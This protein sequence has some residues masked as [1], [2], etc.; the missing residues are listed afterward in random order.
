MQQ[1]EVAVAPTVRVVMQSSTQALDE[2]IVVA[3][4]TSTKASFTGSASVLKTDDLV[5]QRES[6]VK[7]LQG[8][9][10]GVQVG[11]TTGDPGANQ[12]IQIRGISSYSAS[13]QPLYVIDGVAVVNDEHKNDGTVDMTFSQKSQSVLASLNPEDIESVTVLKDA[14]AASLYGSRAANGVIIITTK[15]GKQGS[16]KVSYGAEFGWS[17]MAVGSQYNTMNAEQLKDYY[18]HARK[19]YA[20]YYGGYTEAEASEYADDTIAN[21]FY[22]YDGNTSTNW[23]DEVYGKG[24]IT[25]HQISVSGGNDKTIFYAGLGY[26]KTESIVKGSEFERFSGRLNLDHQAKPWLRVG[27]RQM[28]SFTNSEGFRDHSDQTQGFGTTSPLSIYYSMDPTAPV[29]LEDGSYTPDAGLNA[30]ISNPHLMLGQKTGPNAETVSTDMFRSLSNIEAEITLPYGFTAK[31]ILGYDWI[32]NKIREFWAPE[33]VNGGSLDGLGYRLNSTNKTLTSSTTLNYKGAFGDHSLSGLLGFEVEDRKLL[34]VV[35]STRS[36]STDKLPELANGQPYNATS[37]T[38]ES[39]LMSYFGSLNYD[40]KNTYYLSGSY[41]RDGSS[42]LGPDNRWA[43][44]WSVS[45]AWRVSQLDF[46]QDKDLFTDLKLRASFGT[47]GNLPSAFYASLPTYAFS[48]GY[49]SESA[50]YWNQPGNAELG[51][52]KSNNFNIGLDWTLYSR[53]DLTV[54]YYNKV[55]R[56]LLFQAPVSYVTGF[57]TNWQNVGKLKNYGVE[58]TINSRNIVTK[59]FVWTTNLNFTKLNNKV[60]ELPGGEDITY[61]D[62]SMYILREGESMHSFYLPQW[63]GVNPETGLGEF[64]IDP[65]LNSRDVV[66][67]DGTVLKDANVTNYYEDTELDDDTIIPG[68]GSTIVAKALPDWTGSITNTFYYKNF[69]LSFMISFQTGGSLFDYPGYFVTYSDGVRMGSF[70]MS[71]HVAGNFWK[72]PG[73]V[74]DFPKPIQSNPYR[75]DRFSSRTIKSTDNIRMRD[76]TL[77]YKVPVTNKH[78]SNLRVYFK[79]TNPFMLYCATDFI[80]PDVPINGYRQADT[81]PL[82]TFMFGLTLDF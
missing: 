32:D 70:N 28:V 73:D 10:A 50:I 37:F 62:G 77:G 30:N 40:Y 54:E 38:Y 17:K 4:G 41:R 36:Y 34:T 59:D 67:K 75:S 23:K 80:D 5:S 49:G 76:I 1:Q 13:S 3:Y 44:F 78:I 58:F 25:D 19:N 81:P 68:A 56:D 65:T 74:V 63:L 2:V 82:K 52:E 29:K 66:L 47:N 79:A 26:N 31:T 20:E 71:E 42:K 27:V 12:S 43:N 24:F 45:G 55:T 51:W 9:M 11:G 16:T 39:G 69:D 33:S 6:F 22:D 18:W 14:A 48:G 8:K 21:Y 46:L 57:A 35:T 60:M 64:Y 61:G 7:S 53:V 72:Q 15:K